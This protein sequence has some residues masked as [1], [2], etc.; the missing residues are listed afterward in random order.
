[1]LQF[2]APGATLQLW[3]LWCRLAVRCFTLLQVLTLREL[4]SQ[5]KAL[6]QLFQLL[7]HLVIT[8]LLCLLEPLVYLAPNLAFSINLPTIS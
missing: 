8:R 3:V 4:S 1:M 5:L 6:L 7:D 2:P